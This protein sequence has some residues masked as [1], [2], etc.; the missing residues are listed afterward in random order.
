M[1]KQLSLTTI[2]CKRMYR[3]TY[4]QSVQ[5]SL[6]DQCSQRQKDRDVFIYYMGSKQDRLTSKHVR[7][8]K[9]V[10]F[11]ELLPPDHAS[12][13][14]RAQQVALLVMTG[15]LLR[16]RV[17]PETYRAMGHTAEITW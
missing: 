5:L 13:G 1:M 11:L 6:S 16:S 3:M 17:M 15:K 4:G 9:H 7:L 12:A 14:H 8:E 10:H 2:N